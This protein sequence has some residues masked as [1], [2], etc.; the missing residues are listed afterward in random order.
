MENNDGIMP[1]TLAAR[2]GHVLIVKKLLK[3]KDLKMTSEHAEKAVVGAVESDK[4]ECAKIIMSEYQSREGKDLNK[5]LRSIVNSGDRKQL[6]HWLRSRNEAK[7]RGGQQQQERK[8]MKSK[9]E[10]M[11]DLRRY[12]ECTICYEE[13]TDGEIYSCENDHWLCVNCKL[14]WTSS[15]C[16]T[17]RVDLGENGPAR[18]HMAEKILVEIDT[19]SKLLSAKPHNE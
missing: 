6:H 12:F 4:F 14:S 13:F 15:W 16:P 8:R 17:C 3:S 1:L 7:S 2:E 18:R 11:H 10:V 5:T 19:M 9:E